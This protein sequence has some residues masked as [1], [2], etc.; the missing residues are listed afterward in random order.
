MP[1]KCQD[2]RQRNKEAGEMHSWAFILGSCALLGDSPAHVAQNRVIPKACRTVQG[3]PSFYRQRHWS[4]KREFHSIAKLVGFEE[5]L[6]HLL[7][8]TRASVSSFV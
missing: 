2:L 8:A 1:G 4:S 5:E 7:P 3:Y 6:E